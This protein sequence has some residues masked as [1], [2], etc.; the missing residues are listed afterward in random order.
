MSVTGFTPQGVSTPST[1]TSSS[2]PT[3]PMQPA[4][5]MLR[6]SAGSCSLS[7]EAHTSSLELIHRLRAAGTPE[8]EAPEAT[9]C[10]PSSDEDLGGLPCPRAGAE[11]ADTRLS[12][13]DVDQSQPNDDSVNK[14]AEGD[15]AGGNA[16]GE[17]LP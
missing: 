6:L 16:V 14:H 2:G 17:G 8:Q 13:P 10:S 11:Q 4:T 9:A 3:V 5:E 1:G 15:L 12:M 7:P